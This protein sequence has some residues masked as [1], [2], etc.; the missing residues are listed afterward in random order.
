MDS[1]PEGFLYDGSNYVDFFGG[2]Y[3]FHP[4][5]ALF[6]DEYIAT[7]NE[8]TKQTNVKAEEN[9]HAQQTFVK[10]VC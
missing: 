4:N 1:L 6:I 5:I 3:E 9:R 8:S 7:A 10:R 2:R